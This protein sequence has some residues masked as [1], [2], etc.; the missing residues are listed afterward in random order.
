MYGAMNMDLLKRITIEA[1]KCGGRPCIR[2]TRLRVVDVL[3]LLSAGAT[4][5]EILNDYAFL[6]RD[7]VLAAIEYAALQTDHVI[8]QPA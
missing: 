6:E 8:L 7:D 5:E 1:G 2:G 3:Q 4:V